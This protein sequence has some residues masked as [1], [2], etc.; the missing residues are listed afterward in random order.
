MWWLI[1]VS[2]LQVFLLGE[3]G[4]LFVKVMGNPKR[5]IRLGKSYS[6]LQGVYLWIC[7]AVGLMFFA[8]AL[9]V[10]VVSLLQLGVMWRS[11][12]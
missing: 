10:C 2:I 3:L 11:P 5:S 7:R 1:F 6:F 8:T 4:L 12:S 9:L